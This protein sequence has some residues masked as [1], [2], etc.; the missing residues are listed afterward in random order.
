VTP[1]RFGRAV[2]AAC[3]SDILVRRVERRILELAEV[4]LQ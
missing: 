1:D 4:L 3:K 2:D